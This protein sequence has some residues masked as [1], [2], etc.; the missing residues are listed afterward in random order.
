MR[1]AFLKR[2]Q[3]TERPGPTDLGSST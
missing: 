1:F 3:K 2:G